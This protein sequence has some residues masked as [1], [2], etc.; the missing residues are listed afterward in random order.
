MLLGLRGQP[1]ALGRPPTTCCTMQPACLGDCAMAKGAWLCTGRLVLGMPLCAAYRK[2]S[3]HRA[4]VQVDKLIC[5]YYY[6]FRLTVPHVSG[7]PLFPEH[8]VL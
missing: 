2:Y 1:H 6:R 4:Y 3:K 7:K 8:R 5:F